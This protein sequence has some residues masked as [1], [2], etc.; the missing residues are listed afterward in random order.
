MEM[1][2]ESAPK[3]YKPRGRHPEKALTAAKVRTA[4]PGRYSDGNGL[5]LH[6]DPSGARR[7][8]QRIVIR[9]KRRDLGLGSYSLVT[10]AEARKLARDN[11]KTA[12]SGGDPRTKRQTRIVPTLDEAF[13][14]VVA[15]RR[16]SWADGGKSEGQ[17]RA[18]FRD[19]VAQRLGGRLVDSIDTADVLAVVTP[20]WSAKPVTAK[21][22]R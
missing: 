21:R 22:V 10:L 16:T 18:S 2:V 20:L 6:V 15:I 9:G 19:Y 4:G 12:R 17:W 7:W 11:R 8:V 14:E 1:N 3:G 13:A 5:F